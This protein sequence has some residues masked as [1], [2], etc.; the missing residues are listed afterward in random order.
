MQEK[1]VDV[2][3]YLTIVVL[4]I[5]LKGWLVMFLYNWLVPSIFTTTAIAS[6]ITIYQ[7]VGIAIFTNALF[8]KISS[9]S[10]YSKSED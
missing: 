3:T 4:T 8:V 2:L 7:G 5:F 1:I 6:N 10:N 9:Y